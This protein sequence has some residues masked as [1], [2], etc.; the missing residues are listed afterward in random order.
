LSTWKK[1][2][3]YLA[4]CSLALTGLSTTAGTAAFAADGDDTAPTSGAQFDT[5]AKSLLTEDGVQA[6]TTDGDGNVV[7]YTTE[8]A[9]E[10]GESARSVA[11]DSSNVIVKVLDAPIASYSTD[12]VVGGAGYLA[13]T[14]PPTDEASLC[15]I[16]FSAWSPTGTPAVISAGHCTNDNTSVDSALTLPTGDPAGGGAVTND[17]VQPTQALGT[18]KF[19][20][21]GG[22]GNTAGANGAADSVDISIIDV[23]NQALTNL[24][25]VTD[26]TTT[27]DLS[28]STLPVRSVGAAQVGAAVSKSGRTTGFTSGTVQGIGWSNV[29]GRQVSGFLTN[30]VADHGD[31]GGAIIQG[32]R[33][34][35]I[36]SGG[37]TEGGEPVMWG[38]NLQNGLA[39]TGGYTVALFL[40]APAV[41]AQSTP[42]FTDAP[43]T[44]TGPAGATLTVTPENGTT[45]FEVPIDANGAWSFPAPGAEGN[46]GYSIAA[47]KGFD[48]S[49]ATTFNIDVVLAPPVFTSP[50]NGQLIETSLKAVTGTGKAGATVTLTGDVTGTATVDGAGNWSVPADLSYGAYSIT[51][52][53]QTP[54]PTRSANARELDALA[55]SSTAT[56]AFQVGPVAPVIS[57]PANGSSYVEGSAPRQVT[58]TGIDGATVNVAVNGVQVA[59][60]TVANGQWSAPLVTQLGVGPATITVTQAINGITGTAATSTITVTAAAATPAGTP[61]SPAA[62]AN[63]GAP[64]MPLLG[65]GLALLIAAGGMMLIARRNGVIRTN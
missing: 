30:V 26:W 41:T 22:P 15:S 25:R 34:V 64:V 48:K 50:V 13:V 51:A 46:Y 44:G 18:L 63:T 36:V 65:G 33:A 19:S 29:A 57:S 28:A 55:V 45:P 39:L 9:A 27:A 60:A 47:K 24:P 14:D 54:N 4:V 6:V 20:Q 37:S 56:V 16:G 5:L 1:R 53:Q 58:G 42:Y 59:T 61:G 62:L 40:D 8:P 12:D 43:V 49:A 23:N 32:D 35:G 17:D 21:Y 38:A 52:S 11:E 7:L 31:S 3:A 10:I 2:A